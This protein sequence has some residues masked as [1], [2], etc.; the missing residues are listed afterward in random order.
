MSTA[1][2]PRKAER[3]PVALGATCRTASGLRDNGRIADIS[4]KGCCLVTRAMM[5]K[6]GARIVVRPE[7]MEGLPST[8][9]W[10][11][12]NAIGVE[13]DAPLYLPIVEH[14]CRRY[15]ADTPIALTYN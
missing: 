4:E 10:I 13:F 6:V 14:L 5:V 1:L 11:R 7:G 9:R 2:T 8:V 3:K 15:P 12:G